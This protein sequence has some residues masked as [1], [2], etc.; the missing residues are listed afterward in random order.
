MKP[1]PHVPTVE[2]GF[3]LIEL[4]IAVGI[5]TLVMGAAF[6]LMANSQEGFDRNQLLAEAHQNADFAV[7]RVTEMVRG[8][9]ANPGGTAVVNSV[10]AVSNKEVGSTTN[11]PKVLRIRSD[12]DGDG[13]TISQVTG[14]GASYYILTSEDVTLKFYPN[15]TTVGTAT[16]PAR[17][18]CFIDNT[19]NADH[20][21]VVLASHVVG[22]N[23]TVP[24]DPRQMT[25]SITGGP[26]KNVSQ[27]DPRYVEF[28]RTMQIRVRNLN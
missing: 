19:Q 4:V 17:S 20:T 24:V 3:S 13:Q 2:A 14:S 6:Q 7:V 16:I 18:I 9:G 23:F 1:T 26:S 28:T 10:N 21:P 5:L 27:N 11:D 15:D 22:V 12:Y 8:A 25:I